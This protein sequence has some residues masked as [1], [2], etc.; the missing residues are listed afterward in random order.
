[1]KPR[2]QVVLFTPTGEIV[3]GEAKVTLASLS[4]KKGVYE[5]QYNRRTRRFEITDLAPGPY[6][7]RAEAEGGL[8]AEREVQIGEQGGKVLVNLGQPG[9]PYYYAGERRVYFSP[10]PGIV[11]VLFQRGASESSRESVLALPVLREM[12]ARPVE[13]L[14]DQADLTDIAVLQ[15]EREVS[16]DLLKEMRIQLQQ[17]ETVKD[18]LLPMRLGEGGSA[19][20][21]SEII[22]RFR[23][24]VEQT[25][26]Q[27]VAQEYGLEVVR[28]FPY[29][30][31]TF[32]FR[33]Q[34]RYGLGL[35]EIANG[36]A[37]SD[38]TVYAEPNVHYTMEDDFIPDDYLYDPHQWHLPL[39]N[40]EEAWDITTGSHDI[41]LCVHDRGLWFDGAGNPHPDFDSSGLGWDKI[42]RPWD[43]QDME[44]AT[45]CHPT[46]DHG[47]KCC[48]VAAG[49]QG[50]D[51][52]G[53]TGLAPGCR[54]IPTRR[55]NSNT[56]DEH[57]DAY[58][59][60][61]GF[62]PEST[63][64]DFPAPLAHPADVIVSSF[65]W[66]G[67][68]LSELMKDAF[69][70][71]T[72]YGRNGK[73][74][75]MIFSAG[76]GT[77]DVAVRE[78][79]TY[80]RTIC[81]AA[82][83]D[84]D[85]RTGTSNYG[86][87]IDVC[88]PGPPSG[89]PVRVCTT[90]FVGEGNLAGSDDPGASLDYT[91]NFGQTSCAAPLVAGLAALMLSVNPDLTWVQ[92]REILRST[93][94]KID[95]A[96]T[97]VNGEWVDVHGDRV[98]VSGLDPHFSAWYGYGRIH[99]QM[100][101]E[102]A[103]DL[104]GVD[105]LTHIDTW[106]MENATDVGD[107]PESSPYLSPDVWVRNVAPAL[108][109]PAH[110]HEHQSPIREQDN[111]V[112]ANVR[113][114]GDV[115]SHDVYVRILITRWAGTQYIYPDD[116]IPVIPPGTDPIE[117]MAHGSYFIGEEH[118][119][120]IPAHGVVTIHMRWRR[121][122]IPPASVEI[123]GLVYSWADS[124]LLVE[125]SPHDGPTSTGN[126]TWDNNN[127]CQRNITIRDAPDDDFA[128]AFIV[129]HRT[130]WADLINL[131]IARKHLPGRVKLFVDYVDRETTEEVTRFLARV[132]KEPDLL[133][134]CAL[135]RLTEAQ[136][137][138]PCSHTPDT[139]DLT[140]LTEGQGEIRC[141]KTGET[142]QVV[143]PPKTRFTLLCCPMGRATDYRL[144]PVFKHDRTLFELPTTE[145]AT[146]PVLRKGGE[147]Q[148][149]AIRGT[150][151]RQLKE[152][153]YQIDVYQQDLTGKMDGGVNFIIRKK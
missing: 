19:F 32:L 39:I 141:S 41:T 152:G 36:L 3:S 56:T 113:N 136:G 78:W 60:A 11:G 66:N 9:M 38:L 63:D 87:E 13:E 70:F 72:T 40:A 108:D 67:L 27:E 57:A 94:V 45:P 73:G 103:Q 118:I 26:I 150:G 100:A 79:A 25:K 50:N 96:N 15:V 12:G 122:I 18:V 119:A 86:E 114:R 69:D 16:E 123:D 102:E 54:L 51:D 138:V 92:V 107:V 127:L 59:W 83:T 90:D 89:V 111:W 132:A 139:C 29:A 143:I 115:D 142:R 85:E 62:D 68:A 74:C 147:Y 95:A 145:R 104:V 55:F 2:F 53:I 80:E 120:T 101:V 112:Y 129:G 28:A 146:V 121:E 77:T 34:A 98:S 52:L 35:L 20:L 64:P 5:L 81:V 131:V 61:S 42:H 105:P 33:S 125:V 46:S 75:V 135:D 21:T 48:G 148:I 43:F 110:V 49:L 17:V 109:D 44:D 130:N 153:E 65:G 76:N 134:T 88:A 133:G 149:V 47:T 8:K 22:V 91:D 37:E 116:F 124:C 7:L 99:A 93:A 6:H 140:L 84:G 58:V 4:E 24:E 14:P 126:H 82:T 97:H 106:I 137:E 31:N 151:L 23:T 10:P 117:P 30:P 128:M 1:M 144:K 71:V